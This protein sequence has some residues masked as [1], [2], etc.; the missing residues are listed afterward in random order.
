[1]GITDQQADAVQALAQRLRQ[2]GLRVETDLRN[3]K[4]SYKI[5]EHS[6]QKIPVILVLGNR[7]I[8]QD[9][10]TVRRFG[11]Q[12]QQTLPVTELIEQ[13]QAEIFSKRLPET[14]MNA[15]A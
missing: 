3:A 2:Q 5:R 4:V 7:E 12:A 10:V 15:A 13:L 8:E 14:P 6:L 11:S 1:M 9:T